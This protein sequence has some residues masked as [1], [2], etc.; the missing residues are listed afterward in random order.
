[1][2]RSR[3]WPDLWSQIWKIRDIQVLVIY[4]LMKRCKVETNRIHSVAT[5]QPQS[6]KPIFDFDLTCCPDLWWPGAQI[7]HRVSNSI[8]NR[9]W[10]MVALRAAVFTL[11]SKNRRG[12]HCLPPPPSSARVNT[13]PWS[14][15]PCFWPRHFIGGIPI[16]P[17]QGLAWRHWHK[18]SNGCNAILWE[19]GPTSGLSQLAADRILQWHEFGTKESL[20]QIFEKTFY[21][22]LND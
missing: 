7:L 19:D 11:S 20:K 9:Y 6:Q 1:M 8:V 2:V 4:G 16:R 15:S 10:K 5:A 21:P 13:L 12:G 17:K 22:H 18:W 3:N 14:W